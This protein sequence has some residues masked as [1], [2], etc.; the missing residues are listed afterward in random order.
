MI[1]RVYKPTDLQAFLKEQ[2]LHAKKRLSQ[3][4]LIDGNIIQ[5]IVNSANI[6]A[7][8]FVVEV[9]PGPGALTQA[10]LEK[11]AHVLAVEMDPLFAKALSRLQTSDNRLE[12]AQDDILKFPLIESLRKR[13]GK[14]CKVVANLPYHITT[15]I[16]TLLLPHS[17]LVDSLTIMV[18]KE[19]ADRMSA[20][21][22]TPE[23]SS[24]T[25][26][27]QFYST[28]DHRFT[29]S[30]N[31]FYPRPKVHSSVVHCKLHPPLLN[32]EA[33]GFFQ[34]TRT[35][36]GQRRKMLRSSLKDL[37]GS[38]KVEQALTRISRPITVRPEELSIAEFISLYEILDLFLIE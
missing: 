30:P 1:E 27:L 20:M 12:I 29:V 32:K 6:D 9:G 10:L 23:Y 5:K 8:D 4:F 33:E 26:F 15:P 36:F 28:L 37:Y 18:Q 7:G 2:G 35:A 3:N 19:F 17:D 24:F 38:E 22:G 21:T 25:V 31:C 14:K 16:L 11:G 13:Q 34:L